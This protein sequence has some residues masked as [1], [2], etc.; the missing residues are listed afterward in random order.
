VQAG[1]GM[2]Q[3]K[4]AKQAAIQQFATLFSQN[5]PGSLSPRDWHR[6]MEDIDVGGL[7]HFFATISRDEQQV[8][9]ENRRLAAGEALEINSYDDDPAHIEFHTDFQKTSQYAEAVRRDPRVGRNT[10][11]HVFAHRQ[12]QAGVNQSIAPPGVPPGLMTP[13][14]PQDQQPQVPSM[15][16]MPQAPNGS[17][18]APSR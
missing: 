5:N 6:V 1:S 3:S 12:R 4:A 13:Q 17:S 16:P 10:E 8:A 18:G 2:P 7:E 14:G 9:D 15:P 11:D